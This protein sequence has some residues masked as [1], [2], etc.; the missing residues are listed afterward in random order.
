MSKMSNEIWSTFLTMCAGIVQ[1]EHIRIAILS[2]VVA[3][4]LKI[5]FYY[6]KCRKF[7]FR[8]LIQPSGMPSSHTS[9]VTALAASIGF[10]DG[11]ISNTFAIALIFSVI[12]MYD[13]AG[14]RRAAGRQARVLNILMEDLFTKKR[15]NEL[16]LKE[17]LGHTPLEVFFGVLLGI[18]VAFAYHFRFGV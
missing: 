12:V 6:L 1:N 2:L 13:A 8:V 7:S 4:V 10:S 3:Q 14:V 17:L 9:M 18:I 5:F 15:I 16:R 11:W